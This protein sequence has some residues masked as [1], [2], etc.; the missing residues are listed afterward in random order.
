MMNYAQSPHNLKAE[1]ELFYPHAIARP[2]S[3]RTYCRYYL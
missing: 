2:T 3:V 1:R